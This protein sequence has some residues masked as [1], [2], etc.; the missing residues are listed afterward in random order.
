ALPWHIQA[1]AH[2][3]RATSVRYRDEVSHGN[4]RVASWASALGV[5]LD[6]PG[7]SAKFKVSPEGVPSIIPSESGVKV[8]QEKL[9]AM[10]LDEL[11]RPATAAT[12]DLAAPAAVDASAFTTEQAKALLPNL[13]RTSAYTTY[14]PPSSSRPANT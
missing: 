8:D 10:V 13:V 11:L 7:K 2:D 9:R 1:R 4:E 14:Y 5:V 6:H 12:R 3:A